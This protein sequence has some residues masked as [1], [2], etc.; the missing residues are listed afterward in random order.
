MAPEFHFTQ[1][2]LSARRYVLG[3]QYMVDIDSPH[4]G[5]VAA[6]TCAADDQEARAALD[7]DANLFLASHVALSACVELIHGDGTDASLQ[8]TI[9]LARKAITA[10]QGK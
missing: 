3:A 5:I 4:A 1:G 8:R 10:A 2:P 9:D 7:A 6:L